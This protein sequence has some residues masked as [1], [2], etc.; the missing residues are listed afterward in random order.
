MK[1]ISVA[2][3]SLAPVLFAAA[4]DWTTLDGKT[5]KDVHVVKIEP[6]S[7]TIL[8]DD[9]GA[10][11]MMTNLPPALQKQCGYDPAKAAAF[12]SNEKAAVDKA[13]QAALK[14]KIETLLS[15]LACPVHGKIVQVLNGGFLAELEV[16]STRTVAVSHQNV[17]TQAYGLAAPIVTTTTENKNITVGESIGTVFVSCDPTGLIDDQEWEGVVWKSGTYS[18]TT[19]EGAPRTVAKYTTSEKDAWAAYQAAPE[20]IP[21]ADAP[22]Q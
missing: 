10:K 12:E 13:E 8:D 6:D 4:D 22:S 11:I 3:L 19:V 7:V 14:K 9:G 21:T 1:Q 16:E 18:Y 15:E 20:S 17:N 2:L 5:Y